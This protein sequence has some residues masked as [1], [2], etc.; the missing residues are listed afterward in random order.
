[1]TVKIASYTIPKG[2]RM[3]INVWAIGRDKDVWTEPEKFMPERFLGSAVDF[4]GV[5]FE[6]LPFGAGRRIYPG[7]ALAI[8]MVHVMLASMLNQFRWSLPVELKR[9]G[10]DMEDQFGLTLVK[11]VPLCA[12]A[13][14]I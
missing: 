11:V 2:S 7:M 13:T 9:D 4:K 14:P 8:R 5:D 6:L 12:T 3:F 10:I 1:M